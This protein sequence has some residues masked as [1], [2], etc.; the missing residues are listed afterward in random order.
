MLKWNGTTNKHIKLRRATPLERN[1]L[2]KGYGKLMPLQNKFT[3][4]GGS[5]MMPCL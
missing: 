5:S 3:C 4:Y 1:R 2:G